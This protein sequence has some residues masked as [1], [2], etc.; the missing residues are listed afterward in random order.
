MAGVTSTPDM[1]Q[2]VVAYQRGDWTAAERL[3]K[4]LLDANPD[5]FEA[6]HLSGV[7]ALQTGRS[8]E[9]AKLLSRAVA[10]N[11]DNANVH[12]NLGNALLSLQHPA[13]ALPCYE[14]ALKID[15]NYADAY[16]NRGLVLLELK[17]PQEALASYERALS[18]RPDFAEGDFNRGNALHALERPEEALAS[19]GRALNLRPDYAAAYINRGTAQRD[20]DL[21]QAALESFEHALELRPDDAT[22][23]NN[24]GTEMRD[25]GCPEEA[26]ASYERALHVNPGYADAHI[27]LGLAL[28]ELRRPEEAL[29]G[30]ERA[31]Q[32]KPDCAEAYFNLGNGLRALCRSSVALQSYRRA[33]QIE[34]GHV[35]AH[36]NISLCRLRLGEFGQGWEDYEWRWRTEQMAMDKRNFSQPLWSGVE[37]LAGKTILLHHEQGFGDTLQFSRYVKQ[38]AALGARVVLQVQ[39]PLVPLLTTLEGPAQVIPNDAALPGFDVHCPLLSLPLAFKTDIDSIPA[40]IPYLHSDAAHR[41]LWE[42]RL[43]SRTRP[44]IGLAWSGGAK[45]PNDYNRN[46]AL[47]KMLPVLDN[48]GEYVSLQKEVRASD[49]GVLAARPDIRH[50]GSALDTFADTAALVELMDLVVCVDT[51]VAHLAG[52]MGKAVW[53]LLPF[54]PDWRWL[55]N[56]DDSPW[57]PTAKLFRQPQIGDWSSVIKRVTAELAE[58]LNT[59]VR[60]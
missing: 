10:V 59:Q 25:L 49:A 46:V 31:A 18:L 11:P 13:D 29:K 24:C 5:H 8:Q 27:N 37:P 3:C 44:R 9:A 19:Y 14:A 15:A 60:T 52:A 4:S 51:S 30:F 32:L 55:L 22:A 23:Y 35:S 53:I 7:I 50:F 41:A 38:V 39:A 1:Q 12:S 56:R 33:L 17:R 6:L 43:G 2:A 58:W 28:A 47:G 21:P 45:H 57:Y 42:S 20:L 34:P 48:R 26:L 36:F 40:G 54:S 16:I